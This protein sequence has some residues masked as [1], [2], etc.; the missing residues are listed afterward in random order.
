MALQGRRVR[1]G[2]V[3]VAAA[4]AL[5][6]A[7]GGWSGRAASAQDGGNEAAVVVVPYACPTAETDLAGCEDLAGVTIQ[8]EADGAAVAGSPF[9]SE[10]NSIGTN[11]VNFSAPPDATLTLTQLGGLPEGYAPAPGY[12][13]LTVA[14]ADLELGGCGG[15]SSCLYAALVNIPAVG[16]AE[17]TAAP[18]ANGG[19]DEVAPTVTPASDPGDATGPVAGLPNTGT[20]R[21]AARGGHGGL[22]SAAGLAVLVG[23]AF[24]LRRRLV[25]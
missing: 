24:A 9:T 6:C 12:D 5:V 8:V 16:D 11:S 23:G 25:A 10:L 7:L 14:V 17:P 22:F 3:F 21:A 19:D 2:A 20:G 1:A 18:G 13:P 15:E 4:V